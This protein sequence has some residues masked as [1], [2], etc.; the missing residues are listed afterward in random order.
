MSLEGTKEKLEWR[1]RAFECGLKNTCG[2]KNRNDMMCI[3]N[4]E[5]KNSQ[6]QFTT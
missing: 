3:H 5:V 1:K 6:M 4:D 2:I